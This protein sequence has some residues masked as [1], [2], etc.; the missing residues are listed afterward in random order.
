MSKL[1]SRVQVRIEALNTENKHLI[2]ERDKARAEVK[3]LKKLIG[4]IE[5]NLDSAWSHIDS[6]SDEN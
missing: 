4:A 1:P 3:R 2:Q 5:H 6:Y